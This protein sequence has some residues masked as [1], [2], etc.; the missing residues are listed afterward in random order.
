MSDLFVVRREPDG[1]AQP[2]PLLFVHGAWHAS[3]CWEEHFLDDFAA[4]GYSVAALDLRGHG[5]SPARG[6]LKTTRISDYVDDVA[7]VART[8][9]TPPVVIGHSMGGLIVQ[10]Y[11]EK[12][13]APGGVLVASVPPRGVIGVT[14]DMARHR[15]GAF[16]KANATWSLLPLVKDPQIARELFYSK[17]LDEA[18][19]L[20]Y[21]SRVQDEAYLAFL[22]MLVLNRPKPKRVSTPMLVVGGELDTIFP[23]Q[24]TR[25][26]ARAYGTDAVLFDAAHN[27]M[28]E[29]VWPAVAQTISD[30]LE[31]TARSARPTT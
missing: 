24:D 18:T 10:K 28:L 1:A 4:R 7:E 25:A 12:H 17:H 31:S 13:A 30:W 29:P 27:L 6:R 11:L 15:F 9:D 26:T 22:D 21:A 23:P 20:T 5:A 14:L 16:A 19:A 8:F 2:T 3:W